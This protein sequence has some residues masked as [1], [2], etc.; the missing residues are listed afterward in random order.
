MIVEGDHA[1]VREV[2]ASGLRNARC[3][4]KREANLR[5]RG[6][7]LRRLLVLQKNYPDDAAVREV[8]A[9]GLVDTLTEKLVEGDL[10]RHDALLKELRELQKGYSDD[11]TVR[12]WWAKGLNNAMASNNLPRRDELLEELRQLLNAYPDD[13]NVI[14][15]TATALY[16]VAYVLLLS[17]QRDNEIEPLMSEARELFDSIPDGHPVKAGFDTQK[18]RT[19]LDSIPDG[20]P[21]K[22]MFCELLESLSGCE[23]D[24]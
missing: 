18:T 23:R 13:Y 1:T 10:P 16:Q 9:I 6:A 24:E 15:I 5:R 4:A 19:Q 22:A 17:E 20:H 12:E 8:L 21:S 14:G 11:T 2:L 3:D 7:L